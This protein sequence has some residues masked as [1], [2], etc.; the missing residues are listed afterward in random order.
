MSDFLN[1]WSLMRL[2]MQRWWKT[3]GRWLCL[4]V[5][6]LAA[7]AALHFMLMPNMPLYKWV[8]ASKLLGT[9]VLRSVERILS[10]PIMLLFYAFIGL[11]ACAAI[12]CQ[13]GMRRLLE[14]SAAPCF[15]ASPL[16]RLLVCYSQGLLLLPVALIVYT[17]LGFLAALAERVTPNSI[18][19]FAMF[20]GQAAGSVGQV[21]RPEHYTQLVESISQFSASAFGIAA[22]SMWISALAV[23]GGSQLGLGFLAMR[24][25]DVTV[26]SAVLLLGSHE[27]FGGRPLVRETL[28]GSEFWWCIPLLLGVIVL[29]GHG[30]RWARGLA[31]GSLAM[32][33]LSPAFFAGVL[34]R[35]LFL[36]DTLFARLLNSLR[37]MY[38][39]IG[40]PVFQVQASIGE[41]GGRLRFREHL[42]LHADGSWQLFTCTGSGIL[43]AWLGNLLILAGLGLLV[44]A[45]V[46]YTVPQRRAIG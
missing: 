45:A 35:S 46:R 40:G 16:Q 41:Q 2:P 15:D 4:P 32:L 5:L 24:S 12:G 23:A 38:Y 17:G 25:L 31:L 19:T 11:W 13:Q 36:E 21:L 28:P 1:L 30:A 18:Q 44:A 3:S 14:E 43:L 20:G 26:L 7:A 29:L 37:Y 8:L 9:P 22:L 10:I 42:L 27:V 39:G 6:L 33:A 34:P